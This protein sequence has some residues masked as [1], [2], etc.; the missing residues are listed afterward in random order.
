MRWQP[1]VIR[2]ANAMS[3]LVV[4]DHS[5]QTDALLEHVGRSFDPST[6]VHVLRVA[7]EKNR[8]SRSLVQMP[9]I[10]RDTALVRRAKSV[11]KSEYGFTCVKSSVQC[12]DAFDD[13]VLATAEHLGVSRIVLNAPVRR[14]LL[15][16]FG[17]ES[18]YKRLCSASVIPV[19]LFRAG[20][21]KPAS[22]KHARKYEPAYEPKQKDGATSAAKRR[23]VLPV[24]RS[25]LPLLSTAV[26]QE[27]VC[28]FPMKLVVVGVTV[29][30]VGMAMTEA[31]PATFLTQLH[32]ETGAR[33]LLE[34]EL[35]EKIDS[36]SERFRTDLEV[37][38]DFIEGESHV[39]VS[40]LAHDPA[41]DL[42]VL[43]SGRDRGVFGQRGLLSPAAA[44]MSLP[45]SVMLLDL[46]SLQAGDRMALSTWPDETQRTADNVIPFPS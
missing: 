29:P 11:L 32:G 9:L 27:L 30:S 21:P 25:Q 16:A 46:E 42:L 28:G 10:N 22:V 40:R 45:C 36:L 4:V 43:P 7:T 34:T 44:L 20:Q 33:D 13:A 37:Y 24:T 2:G 6:A 26:L 35:R 3:V 14:G 23:V 17:I 31:N 1:E 12:G 5:S 39:V 18:H 41:T 19:E 8:Q 38:Y 15:T